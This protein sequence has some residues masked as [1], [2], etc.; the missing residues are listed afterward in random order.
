M[1]WCKDS[2]HNWNQSEW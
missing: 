2:C 1:V